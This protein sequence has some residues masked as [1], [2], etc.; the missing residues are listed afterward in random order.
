M[1][2]LQQGTRGGAVGAEHAVASERRREPLERAGEVD[3]V[4][5][6][7]AQH[8]RGGL[9]VEHGRRRRERVGRKRPAETRGSLPDIASLVRLVRGEGRDLSD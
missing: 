1:R 9:R 4:P 8:C 3:G 2:R 5:R 7:S 6:G